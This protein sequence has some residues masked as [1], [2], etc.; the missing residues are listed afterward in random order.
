MPGGHLPAPPPPPVPG[1]GASLP[2]LAPAVLALVTVKHGT[3][4]GGWWRGSLPTLLLSS[5]KH[6]APS[7]MSSICINLTGT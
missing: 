7:S 6:G 1:V 3:P 5:R 4:F 2:A